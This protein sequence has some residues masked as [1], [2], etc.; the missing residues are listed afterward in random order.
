[1]NRNHQITFET[2]CVKKSSSSVSIWP[3]SSV[4]SFSS[5]WVSSQ[6]L[7]NFSIALPPGQLNFISMTQ[8]EL[9]IHRN[10]KVESENSEF[11]FFLTYGKKLNVE[12][13][14]IRNRYWDI[15]R[16]AKVAPPKIRRLYHVWSLCSL[17]G[18]HQWTGP[19]QGRTGLCTL[20][21]T[22]YED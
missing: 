4:L 13:H 14:L 11:Y 1:M 20:I 17:P 15:R 6:S 22:M 19:V 2:M 9:P 3:N 21:S 16:T 10:Y 8:R 12:S 5:S 7:Y 18:P